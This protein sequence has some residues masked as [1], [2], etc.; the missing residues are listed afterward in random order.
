MTDRDIVNLFEQEHPKT[1]EDI[2]SLGLSPRFLGA[3]CSRSA[4]KI[5]KNLVVK[6]PNDPKSRYDLR[7]SASEISF[8]ETV[9][10]SEDEE[11]KEITA[12][13]MPLY[14]GNK[15]T[16]VVVTRYYPD[17]IDEC[18]K[19]HDEFNRLRSFF[20]G[21]GVG[22]MHSGNFRVTESGQLVAIDLGYSNI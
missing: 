13:L 4:Y 16:G 9:H 1:V 12:H 21:Y 3:G 22:D 7:Q 6:I 2:Q 20:S 8:L 17:A 15:E 14:Y 11:T 5:S 10:L 18:G 19:H